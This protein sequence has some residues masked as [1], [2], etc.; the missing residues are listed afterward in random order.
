MYVVFI[1]NNF[2]LT[3]CFANS[4]LELLWMIQQ[5]KSLTNDD[6]PPSCSR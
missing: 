1:V 2:F 5:Y 6:T 4:S 3:A